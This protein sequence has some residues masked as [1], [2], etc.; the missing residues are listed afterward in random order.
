[1][2]KFAEKFKIH[3]IS[4]LVMT[5]IC[6][7]LY[8]L[9]YI[10]S[11]EPG[12]AYFA[13]SS[14][15]Y[16]ISKAMLIAS[17]LWIFTLFLTIPKS[18]DSF[19]F[20]KPSKFSRTAA[21]VCA[22]A[23]MAYAVY[24]FVKGGNAAANSPLLPATCI[25]LAALSIIYFIMA[26]RPAPSGSSAVIAG[27][28][29]IFWAAIAMTDVYTNKYL[30]M[31]NPVKV[32]FILTM[33]SVMFFVLYELRFIVGRGK[34]RSFTVFTLVGILF[35]TVFSV[36]VLVMAS[37]GEYFVDSFFTAALICAA[38]AV[39][40]VSR[41]FDFIRSTKIQPTGFPGEAEC[42]APVAQEDIA[43]PQ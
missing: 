26:A 40:M 25:F 21:A 30:A 38:M 19:P 20:P 43:A 13:P 4:S 22:A 41:L 12:I 28:A 9:T 42:G 14:K 6:T 16:V 33:I 17:L 35:T 5:L 36:N 39:Y 2:T 8:T 37:V 24:R 1:M 10:T 11:F 29:P 34:P 23:F 27:F 3:A 18:N 31:N 7:A 32:T 15:L